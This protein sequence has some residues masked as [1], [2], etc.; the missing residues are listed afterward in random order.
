MS[1]RGTEGGI[2]AARAGHDVIMTPLQHVYFDFYQSHAVDEPPAIH[3]L[4]RLADVYRFYPVPAVL[5]PAL[6]V[7]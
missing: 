6:K 3:G 1:W 5:L 4:T 2:A 7:E